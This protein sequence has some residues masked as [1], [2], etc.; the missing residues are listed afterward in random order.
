[1]PRDPEDAKRVG[2]RE[3]KISNWTI[4]TTNA[5]ARTTT[6]KAIDTLS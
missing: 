3:R 6:T 5:D 4:E 1:M 2:G